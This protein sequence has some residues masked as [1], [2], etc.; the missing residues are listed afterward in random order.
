MLIGENFHPS[1]AARGEALVEC[2]ILGPIEIGH[3]HRVLAL[4]ATKEAHLLAALA[5]DVGRPVGVETLIRRV[6]DDEPPGNP[7]SSIY[8]NTARLRRHMA[9]IQAGHGNTPFISR[10]SRSYTLESVPE[11]VDWYR[12]QRLVTQAGSLAQRPEHTNDEQALDLFHRAESLWRGE[13]LAGLGGLW[14]ETVRNTLYE[15]RADAVVARTA[16]ELRRGNYAEVIE[17]LSDL[18][19]RRPTDEVLVG[20]LMIA[21][22]GRGLHADALRLYADLRRRLRE[23]LGSDPGPE[24]ARTHEMILS[25]APVSAL[26]ST[27]RRRR[28]SPGTPAPHTL[29]QHAPLIGRQRETHTLLSRLSTARDSDPTVSVQSISGM[30]GVGKSLL[31][32]TT[33]E[34]LAHQFPDGLV[35]VNL[36][37]HA[38]AQTS[39]TPFEALT[40]LLRILGALPKSPPDSLAELTVLWQTT[41]SQRRMVVVLDDATNA[42]QVRPLLPGASRSLVLITSRRHLSG[43][44]GN[45]PLT[46]D[47]LPAE[48]AAALFRGLISDNRV[49][50]PEEVSTIVRLCA[51]LPLAVEIA[52][53]RLNSRPGWSL[54][55][56]IKRLSREH[57]RIEELHDTER[58]LS[59]V[60]QVS[61]ATLTVAERSAFRLLS[62]HLMPDFGPHSSAAVMG[63][64]L[65]RMERLIDALTD[66]HL[67]EAPAPERYRYHDLLRAYALDLVSAEESPEERDS[68]VRRLIDFYIAA[69]DAADRLIHP[70]RPR[71]DIGIEPARPDH[72]PRWQDASEA[73]DWLMAEH[74]GLINAAHYARTHGLPRQAA[75]LGHVMAGFLEANGFW[76]EAEHIHRHAVHYWME[77][78]EPA[79]EVRARIDLGTVHAHSGRYEQATAALGSA[80]TVAAETGDT[81]AELEALH[82]SGTLAWHRGHLDAALSVQRKVLGLREQAGDRRQTAR[83]M[84]N[85]GI[86]TLY[87]G[88]YGIARIL[89]GE[90]LREFRAIGDRIFQRRALNNLGDLHVR[91]GETA[92]AQNLLHQALDIDPAN[93]NKSDLATMQ[94]TLGS[95][96]DIPEQLDEALHLFRVALESSRE[97]G[98][99]RNQVICLNEAG[100]ALRRAGRAEDAVRQHLGALDLARGIG[101]V[102]EEVQSLLYLGAAEHL[103]GS[104]R[105]SVD[106]LETAIRLARRAQLPVE[107]AEAVAELA[108]AGRE[109]TPAAGS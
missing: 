83:C 80:V 25:H 106:H 33:A 4:G 44:P 63:L 97:L 70:E 66:T 13:P 61:Y 102:M 76:N 91:I 85:L 72:L 99:V 26:I 32:W 21:S 29:P 58:E 15:K 79:A 69:V 11:A 39:M 109:Y 47:V 88:R 43:L 20:Q 37:G 98:D 42:A 81:A 89:L 16:V 86:F 46:L 56:L 95:A 68:A 57:A 27:A 101:A 75:L 12:Y 94:I 73:K 38:P 108:R 74:L 93:I 78:G 3:D 19:R 107:E 103:I 62:L 82:Q 92:A 87:M 48:D 2:R 28:H 90:A 35:H 41:M 22:H 24:L 54:A 10:R 96:M 17:E 18:V 67:L 55:Y 36:R 50:D 34:H 105:S 49:G 40:Q 1:A 59:V 84:N 65:P 7:L 31:A 8:A 77:A 45:R 9:E 100:K 52:A 53:S 23:E 60:F 51:S 30:A 6:W 5:Y 104:A 71:L 14:A 64:S